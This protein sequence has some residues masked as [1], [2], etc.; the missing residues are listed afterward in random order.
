MSKIYF[1]QLDRTG[2]NGSRNEQ[3]D[4]LDENTTSAENE[5][6]SAETTFY[7][8]K[9][10]PHKQQAFKRLY[11]RQHGK[12]DSDRASELSQQ[13]AMADS[14]AFCSMLELPESLR[15]RVLY[16]MERMDF[17]S[18]TTGGKS[19]E[20]IILAVISLVYDE[21]LSSRPLEEIQYE[22][23]LIFDETFRQLMENN[24]YGSKELRGVREQ[25]RSKSDFF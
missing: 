21:Y 15:E 25:I 18:S 23:R 8:W 12:G 7:Y 16:I 13:R 24:G 17:S 6:T 4:W 19:Y 5:W 10:P 3:E 1:D 9:A 11:D 2:G 22:Q 20:K 14:R